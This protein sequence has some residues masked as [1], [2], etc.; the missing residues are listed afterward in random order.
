MPTE[1]NLRG[2]CAGWAELAGACEAWTAEVNGR[3][4]RAARRPPAEMLLEEQQRLHALA[5]APYTAAF[6]ETRKVTRS[7][8]ISFGGAA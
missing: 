4:H 1:A 8:T 5:E 7:S 2:G 6:G 3:E